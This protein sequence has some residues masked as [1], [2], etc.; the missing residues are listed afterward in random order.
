MSSPDFLVTDKITMRQQLHAIET[1]RAIGAFMVVF[2]HFIYISSPVNPNDYL[3]NSN[4]LHTW[5][6]IGKQGLNML[7]IVSGVVV[8]YTMMCSSYSLV[9]FPK[10][11]L[12]R[13]VRIFP[14]FW[15]A[16]LGVCLIPLFYNSPYP[17]SPQLIAA[18]ASL[19]V[20]LFDN[21][22][23]INPIFLTLKVEF[24]FYLGIGLTAWWFRKNY[25]FFFALNLVGIFAALFWSQDSFFMRLPFFMIG[26][27]L[28]YFFM[29]P[30]DKRFY[31]GLFISTLCVVLTYSLYDSIIVFLTIGITLM[32]KN[33]L[34]WIRIFS[35]RSYS[36]YL[37]HG[38]S[39]ILVASTLYGKGFSVWFSC[40]VSLITGIVFTEI[41]YRIIEKPATQ[42][43]KSVR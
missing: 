25:Y 1:V 27:N 24:L 29:N 43:S 41:F 4:L 32:T 10:F 40:S 20:D 12:R 15:L 31:L 17:Y 11:I 22:P 35:E 16:L 9:D 36:L 19:T 34:S 33:N 2:Y 26:M 7:F 23:W 14:P 18:N 21:L 37:T 3:I 8:Y 39:V 13:I 42:W 30:T 38:M 6:N 5:F 28:S